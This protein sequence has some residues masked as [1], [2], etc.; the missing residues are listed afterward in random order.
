MAN[1]GP[2]SM[3]E[4]GRAAGLSTRGAANIAQRLAEKRLVVAHGRGWRPLDPTE[5]IAVAQ[6]R[7]WPVLLRQVS[8]LTTV[9]AGR[10]LG[11]SPAT[12][13]RARERYPLDA[14]APPTERPTQLGFG[15]DGYPL[16]ETLVEIR[17]LANTLDFDLDAAEKT[18][19]PLWRYEDSYI[20]TR[21][22]TTYTAQGPNP[23]RALAL[24]AAGWSGNEDIVG[25][26]DG[27]LFWARYWA[28]SGRGGLHLFASAKYDTLEA[29]DAVVALL[30]YGTRIK[31]S[32]AP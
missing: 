23:W 17:R 13:H 32:E 22:G 16:D 6:T 14:A 27:T 8:G 20:W 19:R 3:A 28:A 29:Q 2:P 21:Q 9:E 18:L 1:G 26:L 5:S 11:V 10:R 12:I 30:Q 31:P 4:V 15:P 25:A 24:A 7:D